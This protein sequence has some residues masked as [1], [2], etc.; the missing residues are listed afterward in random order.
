MSEDKEDEDK[1]LT[2]DD[3]FCL[4]AEFWVWDFR[5]KL[6]DSINFFFDCF[7]W[8]LLFA[9]LLL[10]LLLLSSCMF[11]FVCSSMPEMWW[12]ADLESNCFSISLRLTP[13]SEQIEAHSWLQIIIENLKILCNRM[14]SKKKSIKVYLQ[15]DLN[16]TSSSC[17]LYPIH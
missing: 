12:L 17:N 9:L 11:S 8:E 2:D 10:L 15:F 6:F 4:L 13:S 16:L 1:L 5:F 3:V 14:K 7:F